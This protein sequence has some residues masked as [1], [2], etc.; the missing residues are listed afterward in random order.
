[1]KGLLREAAVESCSASGS[2]T[3]WGG[4]GDHEK[5]LKQFYF[6]IFQRIRHG[7]SV[8]PLDTKTKIGSMVKHLSHEI[9]LFAKGTKLP[10][11][12]LS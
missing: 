7:G 6:L 1:M 2:L 10:H 9:N 4:G 3:G 8:R 11:L 12:E 5:S